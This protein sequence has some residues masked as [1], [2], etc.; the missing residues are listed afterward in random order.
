M[1]WESGGKHERDNFQIENILNEEHSVFPESLVARDR[2]ILSSM[3][4]KLHLMKTL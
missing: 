3:H 4:L 1:F 2:I